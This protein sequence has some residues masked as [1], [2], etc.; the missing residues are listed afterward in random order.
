MT[1]CSL[2]AL[3]LLAL[4]ALPP[5][6]GA[7]AEPAP[8]GEG[9]TFDGA[10]HVAVSDGKAF[11]LAPSNQDVVAVLAEALVGGGRDSL[12]RGQYS[13]AIGRFVEYVR[14]KP[15]DA[16]GYLDLGRAYPG[17]GRYADAL[18]SVLRGLA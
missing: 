13:E 2:F 7:P 16:R 12:T 5:L 17:S 8:P 10:H 15:T 4:P 9:V 1:R 6:A 14:L 11:D 18:G 3:L